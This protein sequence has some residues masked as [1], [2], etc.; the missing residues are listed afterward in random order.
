MYLNNHNI[1]I[2]ISVD[3]IF[4]L[5]DSNNKYVFKQSSCVNYHWCRFDIHIFRFKKIICI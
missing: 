4:T 1:L 2:I 3:M 5:L